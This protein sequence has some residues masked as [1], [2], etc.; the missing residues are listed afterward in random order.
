MSTRRRL[1][2]ALLVASLAAVLVA[3]VPAQASHSWGSYH[4][5]RTSNP[6]TLQLRDNLTTS[7]WQSSLTGASGDWTQSSVLNTT[8]VPGSI[9]GKNLRRC[10]AAAGRVEICN[11]KYGNNGWLGIASISV[12]G[13]H[14]TAGTVKVND[15]YYSTAQYNTPEWRNFVMC[16]EVGHIFGLDH[17]DEDFGNANLGTCM[18]YTSNPGTNQ[19]PNA[20]D[21]AQ[22]ETI[23]RHLD[24]TSTVGASSAA[25]PAAAFGAS[26]SEWGQA[27]R[28]SSDGRPSLFVRELGHDTKVFTFV[29]WAL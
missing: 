23:Y 8:V 2:G 28:Y 20:H 17:Q 27:I 13:G 6:F 14:I 18:D 10:Q 19:H 29:V 15:T 16:Q 9:T 21:Y 4:W 12:S 24:S 26:V 7:Q 22:L 3:A 25:V 5:A 11:Y 1:S